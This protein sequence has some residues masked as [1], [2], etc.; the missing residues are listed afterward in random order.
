MNQ[1]PKAVRIVVIRNT[2]GLHARPADMF[3]KRAVQYQSN[4]EVIK[5]NERV[6]GKSILA[7]LMLAAVAGTELRLEA[8]GVDAEAA[9]D[10]LAELVNQ[11][12]GE[13]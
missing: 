3:V 2:Q 13:E 11:G 12:F 10:S 8:T 4:I 6:D 1:E 9:L 5:D 7:I